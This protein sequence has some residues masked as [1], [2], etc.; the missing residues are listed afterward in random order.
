MLKSIL[1]DYSDACILVSGTIPVNRA[2][3]DEFAKRSD[4]RNKKVIFQNYPAFT[5][6]IRKINYT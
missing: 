5:G 6:Y 4:K 2:G 3:N 1:C